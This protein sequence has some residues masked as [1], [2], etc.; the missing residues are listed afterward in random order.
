VKFAK[1]VPSTSM[2]FDFMS[3]LLP[4]ALLTINETL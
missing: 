3:V 2:Y 1:G 4:K